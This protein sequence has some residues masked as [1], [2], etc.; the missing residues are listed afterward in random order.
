MNEKLS[1]EK[2]DR[3]NIRNIKSAD[4]SPKADRRI[5]ENDLK[6]F[7]IIIDNDQDSNP[8]QLDDYINSV[9]SP[10]STFNMRTPTLP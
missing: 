1:L 6:K 8:H 10:D 9:I 5:G 4:I 2:I 3:E 7:G